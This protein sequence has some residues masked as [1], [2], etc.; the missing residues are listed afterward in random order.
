ML[1]LQWGDMSEGRAEIGPEVLACPFRRTMHQSIELSKGQLKRIEVRAV[2]GEK[3]QGRPGL[4]NL[5]S[6][7][8]TFMHGEVVQD[9]HI[10]QAEG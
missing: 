2:R 6:T 1:A 7:N 9:D 8:G 4:L 10:A 3:V 5:L